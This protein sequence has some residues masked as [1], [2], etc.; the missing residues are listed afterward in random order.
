MNLVVFLEVFER[1]FCNYPEHIP[2]TEFVTE[3]FKKR[4]LFR[5][6][7]KYL[8][9]NI[10]KKIE[11]SVDGVNIRK[12]INEGHKCAT[13]NWMRENFDD[14]VKEW[15]TLKNGNLIVKLEDDEGV[16]DYDKA[17][18][19]NIMPSQS[20]SYILSHSKRLMNEVINQISGF[21]NKSKYYGVIDSMYLHKNTGVTWL[22]MDLLVNLLAWLKMITV[23]RVYFVLGFG[24]QR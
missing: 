8:L 7:E 9:Q 19:I 11:L 1:F 17:K 23:T 21:Y 14:W 2:Y 13:E 5:S 24:L 4:D 10:A 22:I 6:K 18:S 20:G 15:F 12:D 3:M 16:D